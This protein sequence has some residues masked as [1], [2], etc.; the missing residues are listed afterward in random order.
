M[1]G[2]PGKWPSAER[3]STGMR[4]FDAMRGH[5]YVTRPIAPLLSASRRMT[6]SRG[7]LPSVLRGNAATRCSGRGRKAA[8]IRH[9]SAAMIASASRPGATANAMSRL[10]ASPSS[11]SGATK[12]PS[13]TPS[14]AFRW[15]FKF[16]SDARLPGNIDEI[17]DPAPQ[18]EP[19]GIAQYDGVRQQG[20]LRDRHAGCPGACCILTQHDAIEAA[21]FLGERG[22][23]N[24]DLPGLRATIN[25][26]Q[27]RARTA[28]RLPRQ[29]RPTAARWPTAAVNRRQIARL[30]SIIRKCTGV[31]TSRRG[32][33]AAASSAMISSG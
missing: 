2:L 12:T 21:P 9:R 11:S 5:G 17:G 7:S 28:S 19:L 32:R 22:A 1:I 33:Q 15:W 3:S 16:A 4:Q 27:R 20:L 26:E 18:Q 14:I 25:L 13:S 8:S 10:T 23:S 30:A 6:S 24:G 29:A 31:V